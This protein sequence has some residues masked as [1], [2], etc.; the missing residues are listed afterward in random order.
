MVISCSTMSKISSSRYFLPIL[1]FGL[2]YMFAWL[3]L[4][5]GSGQTAPGHSGKQETKSGIDA[6][7]SKPVRPTGATETERAR[8][9]RA[10][11]W[12]NADMGGIIEKLDRIE[13]F[14]SNTSDTGLSHQLCEALAISR[15]E[16]AAIDAVI[17]SSLEKIQRLQLS[18]LETTPSGGST[19]KFV[20][21]QFPNEGGAVRDALRS[22]ILETLGDNRYFM[23]TKISGDALNDT[24]WGFG[25]AAVHVTMKDS[26]VPGDRRYETM[27]SH[28]TGSRRFETENVP[29]ALAH[30]LHMK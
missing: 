24:F 12:D 14:E 6:V 22:T 17:Q 3:T 18:H 13:T 11:S 20:I 19:S 7:H 8:L 27:L 1:F 9:K 26:S 16:R 29:S 25:D 23:F 2:G 28:R 5:P 30:L 21:K 15:T 4:M 10:E